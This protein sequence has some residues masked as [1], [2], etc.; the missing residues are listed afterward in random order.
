MSKIHIF[1]AAILA[2]FSS[3]N[4]TAGKYYENLDWIRGSPTSDSYNVT[5][6]KWFSNLEEAIAEC[7]SLN[8]Y[9]PYNGPVDCRAQGANGGWYQR[10]Y[11]GSGK[12]HLL[13]Y[14]YCSVNQIYSLTYNGCVNLVEVNKTGVEPRPR[15]NACV[16]NPIYPLTGNKREVLSS[17][18]SLGSSSLNFTFDSLIRIGNK[19]FNDSQVGY[20]PLKDEKLPSLGESWSSSM[21]KSL[22][23]KE[24]ASIVIAFRGDGRDIKFSRV[25]V[26]APVFT[27]RDGDGYVLIK[28]GATY[29]LTTPNGAVEVYDVEGRI[30]TASLASGEQLFFTYDRALNPNGARTGNMGRL[31]EVAEIGSGRK[32]TF[33]YTNQSLLA[34]V[35]DSSGRNVLFGYDS[36]LNLSTVTFA[37]GKVKTLV[38][39]DAN[40]PNALTGIVDE[41]SS[42]FSMFGYNQVGQAISTEYAGGVNKF[43]V[44]YPTLPNG[45]MQEV[46]ESYDA[47]SNT[48]TRTTSPVISASSLS[49]TSPQGGT[50]TATLDMSSEYPQL[51]GMSQPAGSGCAASNASS[52]FDANGNVVAQNNFQGERTCYAFDS[53]NQEVTRV[54]GLSNTVDCATVLPANA[55]LPPNAR[56][57]TTSYHPDWRLPTVTTTPGSITTSI[58]HGQPDPFNGNAAASCTAAPNMPNGKPLPVLCKQVV[59]AT[60]ANG[61]LDTSTANTVTQY[62]YNPSGKVLTSTDSLNRTTSYTYYASTAFTGTD[63]NAAGNTVGDLQTVTNPAGFVTTFN[64]YDKTGR[65]LKTT[66]PKG[67]VTDM[68]YTPRGWVS[69][70]TTTAPGQSGRTT[71]YSYDNVGQLTGVTN[72]DGSTLAYTYDAAHRL[73]GAT[74]AKGNS[75]TYTLDNMGN[76]TKEDIKDPTGILQRSI[77]RSFDALNRLQQVS[78]AVQ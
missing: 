7:E 15:A 46:S 8:L 11:D 61:A 75:V 63:P 35:S 39:E 32:L 19:I 51:A 53:N 67:I 70:V 42:R 30:T 18:L 49:I 71:N 68:T 3:A 17:G 25:G 26:A 31:I 77:N 76:R 16:G 41:N 2:V 56:K 6:R 4:A 22:R 57:T 78:G 58:Y 13:L 66:D 48:L 40:Y 10:Y 38:Y 54:E 27:N 28:S 36:L 37:D 5:E 44:S 1:I 21:H 9:V 72:P 50:S 33:A 43:Q 62:T 24:S 52:E 47:L 60:L 12:F 73:T 45:A 65:V 74:D 55:I 29:Q 64:S 23:L 34:S 69:T 14:G 59:Q 20:L